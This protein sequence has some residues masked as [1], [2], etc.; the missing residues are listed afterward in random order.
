M[1]PDAARAAARRAVGN[2]TI[3]RH[4]ARD[5]S[6][7]RWVEHLRHDLW[8]AARGLRRDRMLSMFIVLTLAIGLGATSAVVSLADR[9]FLRPPA[10][11]VQPDAIRRLYLRTRWTVGSVLTVERGTEYAAFAAIDSA[12]A[13]RARAAGYVAPDTTVLRAGRTTALVN[14]SYVTGN[15]FALLGVH[16]FTGRLIAPSD[17]RMGDAANSR[18]AVLS[19]ATWKQLFGGDTGIVGRTVT[20]AHQPYVIIGVAEPNF[21]GVDVDRAD[22][23]MPIASRATERLTIPWYENWR[24]SRDVTALLRP[25][26]GTSDAWLAAVATAVYRRGAVAHEK[27]EP[28]STAEV[29][30]GPILASLGPGDASSGADHHRTIAGRDGRRAA[31]G[32]RQRRQPAARAR[33]Q[34]PPRGRDPAGAGHPEASARSATHVRE[35]P[36]VGHGGSRR[37]PRGGVGRRRAAGGVAAVRPLGARAAARS[38]VAWLRDS[39]H[40]V[41]GRC[42]GIGAGRSRQSS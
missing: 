11:V 26:P 2:L 25:R 19:Y 27:I 34:A 22:V 29:L 15:Y 3:V 32:M 33:D 9:L 16:P 40:R 5:A 36:P 35:S 6:R 12:I 8:Y 7:W 30:T 18:V 41:G 10:R 14:D 39:A 21:A 4:D 38:P 23:W 42:G 28:D 20:L 31:D 1:S 13:P 37:A 24:T 17:D